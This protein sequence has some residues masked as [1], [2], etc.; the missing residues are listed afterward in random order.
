MG[1]DRDWTK[2]YEALGWPLP[3]MYSTW[4]VA[5]RHL[6]TV[7]SA[8]GTGPAVLAFLD[9]NFTA[10]GEQI[11]SVAGS[12]ADLGDE[13]YGLTVRTYEVE[14]EGLI[15]GWSR[16][17]AFEETREIAGSLFVLADV[18]INVQR[19]ND[20]DGGWSSDYYSYPDALLRGSLLLEVRDDVIVRAV[21]GSDEPFTIVPRSRFGESEEA[22]EG[23]LDAL[24]GVPGLEYLDWPEVYDGGGSSWD[25]EL[26]NGRGVTLTL[27]GSVLDEW[28]LEVSS[29]PER[30]GGLVSMYDDT[31]VGGSDGM[32]M[33]PPW[34]IADVDGSGTRHAEWVLAASLLAHSRSETAAT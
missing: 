1:A 11:G 22:F 27:H 34:L 18:G 19:Y 24:R 13:D 33:D 16:L 4:H 20:G 21:A 23:A 29:G 5:K 31:W 14:R 17:E 30:M 26:V 8:V 15:A 6:F 2:A 9:G 32:F 25:G 3:P 7:V 12:V 28:T 10:D